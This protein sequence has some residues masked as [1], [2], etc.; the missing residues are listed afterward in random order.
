MFLLINI[1]N[2]QKQVSLKQAI[3]SGLNH[4]KSNQSDKLNVS[5]ALLQTKALYRKYLP[6]VSAEYNFLYNPILQTSILPIGVFNPAFPIDATKSVQFGTK[7][8]QTAGLSATQTLLDLS[9]IKQINEFKLKERIAIL[10]QAQTE[11]E[12]VYQIAQSYIQIYLEE[13]K[14]LALVSDTNRTFLSYD[15]MKNQ[16]D[17]KRLLKSDLNKAIINHNNSLQSLHT[18]LVLLIENKVNLLYLMGI[19]E[20]N[21]FDFEIDSMFS[22]NSSY[23]WVIQPNS[24]QFIPE[25]QSLLIQDELSQIQTK[26]EMSKHYPVIA[27]KGYLGASQ[28][29]NSFN[30]TDVNT[31]FGLS[32]VGLNVKVPILTGEN[33]MN[34]ISQLKLQS[35][36]FNY[37]KEDKIK[38]YEKESLLAKTKME[39]L[40]EQI[41]I[42]S[43]NLNLLDE[44]ISISQAR[45]SEGKES[46]YSLNLEE[47]ELQLMQS[48]YHI[49]QKQ[50][51]VYWLDYLKSS[52]Q[53]FVLWN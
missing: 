18:G 49:S 11:Y 14:I 38:F 36:Q 41:K 34:K 1:V 4:K 7:W 22:L 21:E 40:S 24:I 6:Q 45:V 26:T 8:T 32:Y 19:D 53:L 35:Q 15:M 52:G 5:I 46:A 10:S 43:I 28:F 13:A 27:L 3:L 48:N 17:E 23:L 29:S 2:A 20:I 16:F 25:L 47:V 31:W 42:Q 51:W 33:Q 44:S 39:N 9:I 30:P 50:L 12:L 37:Q